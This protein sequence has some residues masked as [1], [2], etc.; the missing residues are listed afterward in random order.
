MNL[1][2]QAAFTHE[3]EG[4]LD[5]VRGAEVALDAELAQLLPACCDHLG[6]LVSAAAESRDPCEA[7]RAEGQAL[8]ARLQR[9]HVHVRFGPDLLRHGMDPLSIVPYLGTPGSVER[10]EVLDDA[11]PALEAPDPESCC[12]GLDLSTSAGRA[13]VEDAFAFVAEDCAPRIEPLRDEVPAPAPGPET[14]TPAPPAARARAAHESAAV[15]IDA[16]KLDRLV[17]DVRDR[18]LQLRSVKIGATFGRFQRVVHD[19][20]RELG[21]DIVL[22]VSG[23]DTELDHEKILAKGIERGS[24]SIGSG[25]GRGTTVSVRRPLTL[26]LIDGFQVGVRD[27]VFVVPLET[28]DECVEYAAR[29]DHDCTDLRGQVWP[30]VRLRRFFGLPGGAGGRQHIVV[31]HCGGRRF[32]LVVDRLHGEAQTVIKPLSKVF[33]QVEGLAGSSILGSGDVALILDLPRLLQRRRAGA[34]H[35]PPALETAAAAADSLHA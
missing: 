32:G 13:A 6:L 30:F 12:L 9:W 23:E 29:D 34:P 28:V 2:A 7:V 21:K 1:D 22:R 8:A 3:A 18:A 19:V 31:V 4:V 14:A 17:Q 20:A 26:A 35:A 16:D 11:V 27:A 25:A 24:V 5:R 10:I 15:R 33:A